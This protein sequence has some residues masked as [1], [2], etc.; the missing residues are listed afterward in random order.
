M[1]E[2]AG[3]GWFRLQIIYLLLLL[4]LLTY[5]GRAAF[6]CYTAYLWRLTNI[7]KHRAPF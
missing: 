5:E 6:I 3:H 2:R 1:D 4:I 7:I